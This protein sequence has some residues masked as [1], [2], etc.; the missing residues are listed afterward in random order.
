MVARTALYVCSRRYMSIELLSACG[1]QY[2][3]RLGDGKGVMTYR[4]R[5]LGACLCSQKR[6][7]ETPRRQWTFLMV[8]KRGL[9]E[10]I[11]QNNVSKCRKEP[12]K[13]AQHRQSYANI[14]MNSTKSPSHKGTSTTTVSAWPRPSI[15]A[16]P[17]SY[18]TPS[19]YR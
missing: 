7:A 8:E 6:R 10:S 13:T 12:R 3:Q 5:C 1:D 4:Q 11:L 18:T 17:S 16:S 9:Q 2:R 14:T 15:T 19:K